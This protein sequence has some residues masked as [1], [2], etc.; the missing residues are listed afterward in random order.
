MIQEIE[1]SSIANEWLSALNIT[2]ESNRA[3]IIDSST[4]IINSNCFEWLETIPD[5]SI[6]AVVTD[7]PYG[8]KEFEIEQIKKMENRKGGIWRLP[9]SFDGNV[10]SPLPRFTALNERELKNLKDFFFLFGK[11]ISRKLKPGGHMFIASNSFLSQLVYNSL[12]NEQ[13]EFRGEI[14]RLVRTMRGGDKP[15]NYENDFPEVCTLPR[16]CY[17]PWGIFRKKIPHKM[18]V[19]EC[20]TKYGTGGLRRINQDKPFEDVISSTRTPAQERRIAPHPS[21]KPQEFLR[22]IV[23]SI[24]PLGEGIVLDP[25]MGSGSTLAAARALHYNTIG[26]EINPDYFKIAANSIGKLSKI[27]I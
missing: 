17:E 9:P 22:K 14:I 1:H 8:V 11:I 25:F 12:A 19:G 20:L 4:L 16:G 27:K 21:L 15:K 24:L 2:L 23:Y 13:L 26:I 7:P 3:E 10:R 18:T 5:N 6:S